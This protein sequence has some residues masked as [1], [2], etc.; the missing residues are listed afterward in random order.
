[1]RTVFVRLLNED[2]RES[3]LS[4][5]INSCNNGQRLSSLYLVKSSSFA[6]IP[7]SPFAYW[8][9]EY[10][11]Q[12][13]KSLQPLEGEGREFRVGDHPGDGFRFLRLFWEVP[14]PSTLDWRNYQKGGG[15]SPFY[16][17]IH[18]VA[19][20]DATRQTYR[21]FSGRPGRANERPS[22]YQFFFRPGI[23]WPRR[24]QRGLSV[25]VLPSGCVFADKG[26]VVFGDTQ[27]VEALLGLLNS[28]AFKGLLAL[29][30]AFGSFETGAMQRTVI[31]EL[32]VSD[33]E[34]LS[35]LAR[36]S[37]EIK[38]TVDSSQETSHAFVLPALLQ[39]ESESLNERINEWTKRIGEYED[40]L[41]KCQSELDE[42]SFRLYGI[43]GD[44]RSS[45][46]EMVGRS[47][48]CT[49]ADLQQDQQTNEED[50]STDISNSPFELVAQLV[51]YAVGAAF[52]RWNI[53][54]FNEQ[55]ND[56]HNDTFA[57]LPVCPPGMLQGTDGL[58]INDL[59]AGYPLRIEWGGILADDPD[60]NDDIVRR[61][62]DF[63]EIIWKDRAEGVE[64]E[65]CKIL[66]VKELRDYFRKPGKG[67]FW[68]DHLSRYSK[69]RRNAPIYW[70]LQSSKKNYGLWL[71][72]HRLGKDLLFKALVSYVEPKIR[73]ETSRLDTLRSQKSL[74]SESRKESKRLSKEIEQQEELLTEL[75][76]FED[77]LRRAAKL[78]FDPDL[79]DGVVLNVAPLY[80]LVPWKE[81]KNYW[82]DL[83]EGKYEWSSIAKQ[84]R[85]KG[86]VKV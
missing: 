2:A 45:I 5:T 73:L 75:R 53:K 78:H 48:E 39:C 44:D 58:P 63:V 61:V 85:Q 11:R 70:L 71:Y 3:R 18:L 19:D 40:Q 57:P 81:A 9:S 17:D 33:R 36:K 62:R 13:F 4:E 43:V 47:R 49:D 77:K 29:Q 22:N 30:M 50:E 60:H 68:D 59:P 80:E 12:L 64:A 41:R 54:I 51:S 21:G 16:Y 31:P 38:R 7:G 52:G 79:N 82:E 37:F 42:L 26:P 32:M 55:R 1:M 56:L 10:C 46:E 83:L 6:N 14:L 28:A 23:T 34:Q 66:G 65:A 25:R 76:D 8:L 84:L 86:L 15:F 67:G 35:S 74:A 24:S 69:S 72:Y 20:W 27:Q